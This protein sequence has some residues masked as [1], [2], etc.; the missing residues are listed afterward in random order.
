MR[1]GL[2]HPGSILRHHQSA[3]SEAEKVL[4]A[5]GDEIPVQA[6]KCGRAIVQGIRAN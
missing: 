6:T 5:S 4:A 3:A 1:R 2:C